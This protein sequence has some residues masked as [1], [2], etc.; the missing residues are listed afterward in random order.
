MR[1]Q[2]FTTSEPPDIEARLHGGTLRVE[3][4][5]A[6]LTTVE[7][8]PLNDA[9]AELL[10]EVRIE[11][12]AARSVVVEVPDRRGS[13]FLFRSGPEFDVRV[14]CPH[15]ATLDARTASADVY[16]RGR[17]ASV[18]ARTAS[19]DV[20]VD[21]V[22]RTLEVHSAS[23]DVEVRAAGSAELATTSGDVRVDEVHGALRAQ[24]VSG[25]LT[26]G[27]ARAA[28]EANTVSGDQRID[29]VQRGLVAL[30]SVSGD[31]S[32]AVRRGARVWLDV[33]SMSGDTDSEL[34]MTGD[35]VTSGEAQVEL[36]ITT[37]S[38]DVSIRRAALPAE[39]ADDPS[40]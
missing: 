6:G 32:V 39:P 15:G 38:G 29:A 2:T 9:A 1:E 25:D 5:A 22:E 34:D 37:V 13:G 35:E 8:R 10:G 31:V 4:G 33:R 30:R 3:T 24:L 20:E 12:R 19:G 16:A 18:R 40:A 23:G 28:V 21:E 14:T 7:V 36:R 26:V 11:E 27:D 17:Y